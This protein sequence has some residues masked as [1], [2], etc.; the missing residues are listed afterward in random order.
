MPGYFRIEGDL[1]RLLELGL[2]LY[3]FYG[4]LAKMYFLVPL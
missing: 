1:L 2:F 3:F 4:N